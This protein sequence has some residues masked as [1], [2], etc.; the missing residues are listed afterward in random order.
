[1]RPGSCR[2]LH[3][4][5]LPR[6]LDVER[7]GIVPHVLHS[8]S[9]A[10]RRVGHQST[11]TVWPQGRFH[12]AK[13]QMPVIWTHSCERTLCALRRG[14]LGSGLRASRAPTAVDFLWTDL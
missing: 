1:M 13:T 11:P 14:V 2:P 12:A 10:P 5:H 7:G 8:R 6:G 4:S 9:R 3:G